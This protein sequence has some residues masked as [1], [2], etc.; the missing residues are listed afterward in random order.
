M[1]TSAWMLRLLSLLQ[2]HRYWPGGAV[3]AARGQPA[4]TAARHRPVARAGYAVD[5]GARRRRRLPAACRRPAPPRC[6]TTT[7]PSRSASRDCTAASGAVAGRRRSPRRADEGDR[8]DA[9]RGC[10][11][12][13]TRCARRPTAHRGPAARGRRD[14][15]DRARAGVPRR[16]AGRVR[17]HHARRHGLAAPGRA[18]PPGLARAALVPRR[19]GPRPPGLALL[20]GRPG[21][22]GDAE[23][24]AV[25][26]A[27]AP[28]R[29][30]GWPSCSRGSAA[31]RSGYDVRLRIALP[32]TSSR[33]RSVAGDRDAGRRR[34]PG[35][36]ADRLARLAALVLA[37]PDADF[38]V[39]DPPELRAAIPLP[40]SA[41]RARSRR[42]DGSSLGCSRGGRHAG[43]SPGQ[44]GR[45]TLRGR[46]AGGPLGQPGRMTL[47]GGH[48]GG[49]LGQPGRM[50]LR[51][52]HAGGSSGQRGRM[53]LRGGHAPRSSG[54]RGR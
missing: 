21:V 51:G 42:P 39:D 19:L 14:G 53:T 22:R 16:R 36:P 2:T 7:R 9:T 48:A 4:H 35:A 5:R 40:P 24:A 47:R 33:P 37:P 29:G 1:S 20:P 6:S 28:R 23:R 50:T 32:P 27:R 3:R 44:P 52:R 13:W 49:S 12:G 43:R 34:L 38:I 41:S 25:P 45:M 11:T 8:P 17:L 15:A 54:Q 26:A 46:H 31:W 18:P 10:G 30:R